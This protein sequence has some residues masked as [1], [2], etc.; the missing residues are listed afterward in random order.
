MEFVLSRGTI[1]GRTYGTHK[2]LPGI[3]VYFAIFTNNISSH[4]LWSPVILILI[5]IA[6]G[7]CWHIPSGSTGAQL[8]LLSVISSPIVRYRTHEEY[9]LRPLTFLA[10][11]IAAANSCQINSHSNGDMYRDETKGQTN[12]TS[13]HTHENKNKSKS[14]HHL[15]LV[16]PGPRFRPPLP[17]AKQRHNQPRHLLLVS[18][19]TIVIRTHHTCYSLFATHIWS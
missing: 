7:T 3:P 11:S 6:R 17:P 8:G 2:N 18:Q 14:T 9:C 16:V 1:V 5:R 10:L 19:G 15:Q 4:L 12:Q 13:T